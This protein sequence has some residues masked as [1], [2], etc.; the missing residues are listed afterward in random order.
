[1]GRG[2]LNPLALYA[3]DKPGPDKFHATDRTS[4]RANPLYLETNI[5]YLFFTKM[6]KY[7]KVFKM[8]VKPLNNLISFCQ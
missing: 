2:D 3:L 6:N 7:K 8:Q 5:L 4:I 1:M